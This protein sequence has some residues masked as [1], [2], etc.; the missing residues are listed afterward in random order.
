MT[1]IKIKLDSDEQALKEKLDDMYMQ[2]K[3][4][5]EKAIDSLQKCDAEIARKIVNDDNLINLLQHKIEEI[6]VQTIARRQPVASD[7]RKLMTDIYISMELERIADHAAAIAGI[8]VQLAEMPDEKYI[9]PITDMT[10]QC[11]SML[12]LVKQAYD[13]EDEQLARKIAVM[14]DEIDS[15]EQLVN[16]FMFQEMSSNPELGKTCTYIL[17]ITHNLERVGDRITNI[18]ERVVYMVTNE[19]PDLN[20]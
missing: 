9:R 5:L 13:E 3:G 20:R 1:R 11:C 7:L 18:A 19:T 4:A 15:A 10:E 17:W 2:V 6:G 12:M 8:V 14:D 16:D